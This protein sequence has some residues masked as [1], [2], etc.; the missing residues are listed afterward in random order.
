MLSL[1]NYLGI[2]WIF[3][4]KIFGGFAPGQPYQF[5]DYC[6]HFFQSNKSN[7]KFLNMTK[8]CFLNVL[9]RWNLYFEKICSI[10]SKAD[11]RVVGPKEIFGHL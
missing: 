5:S 7:R 2:C 3:L 10:L 11:E 1:L 6:F 8:I 4:G 9:L